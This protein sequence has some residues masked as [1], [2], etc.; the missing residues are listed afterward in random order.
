MDEFQLIDDEKF[1][2][3]NIVD[4]EI[5]RETSEDDIFHGW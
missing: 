3:S 1:R 5:F 4:D 2:K